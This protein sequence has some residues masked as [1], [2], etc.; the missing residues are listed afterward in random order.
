MSKEN[1][2][3]KSYH[4]NIANILETNSEKYKHKLIT[5][6]GTIIHLQKEH[7]AHESLSQC[8]L[9]ITTVGANTAELGALG[10]PMLVIVPTQH[11]SVMQA[12]DGFF[13]VIARLP[14]LK[15]FFGILLSTWRLRN[16]GFLAW[17]NISA[18]RMIVPEKIGKIM[19]KE[20][21]LEAK[22]WILSPNRL[23]GQK[24]DLRSLRGKP[25]AVEKLSIEIISLLKE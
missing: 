2:I 12:W 4:S 10:V 24:E 5:T 15:W 23:Q 17:P 18:G 13:G 7:P 1:S 9:A 8:K 22:D 16:R 6:A 14:I 11:L 20:I 25:G 21:A 19:P 3:A